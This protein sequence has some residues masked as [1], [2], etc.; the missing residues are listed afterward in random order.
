MDLKLFEVSIVIVGNDCNPTILNPDFLASQKIVP[1]AWG[2][3]VV[4]APITTPPFATAAY[5]SGVAI[6][7]DTSKVQ[8]VG[9]WQDDHTCGSVAHIARRYVEVLPHVRYTGVGNNFRGLSENDDAET[10][11]KNRFLK[12]GAWDSDANS[13]A[14]AAIKFIYSRPGARLSL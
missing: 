5:D 14:A 6:T 12:P 2:W 11:L 8:V 3:Q 9:V 1:E 7:V 13:I 10:F 4:G